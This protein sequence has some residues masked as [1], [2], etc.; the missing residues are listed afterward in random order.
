M[1]LQEIFYGSFVP[2][3]E[4]PSRIHKIGISGGHR[5]VEPPPRPSSK[6]KSGLNATERVIMFAVKN[7]SEPISSVDVASKTRMNANHC[8]IVL[9]GLFDK[10]IVDRVK[11]CRNG[12][13]FFLYTAKEQK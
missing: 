6:D 1:T 7:S 11:V 9:R 10:K 13:R 12:T 8:S 5:Y 3:P 4:V 2:P